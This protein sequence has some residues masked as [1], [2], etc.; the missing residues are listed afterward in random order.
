[1]NFDPAT[2]PT[3]EHVVL[4]DAICDEYVRDLTVTREP[5]RVAIDAWL[6]IVYSLYDKPLPARI[7]VVASP[8]AALLLATEL[9][10]QP[11]TEMDWCGIGDGGWVAFEDFFHRIGI[12]SDEEARETLALRDFSRVAW[13]SVL[14]D[15]CGGSEPCPLPGIK[16]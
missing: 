12:E 13:D 15:D 7:E 10:G 14:L 8:A 9:T 6:T 2:Y 16:R 3:P 5:D 1:M 11:Q 4:E